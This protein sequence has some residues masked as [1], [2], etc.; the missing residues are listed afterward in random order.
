MTKPK[1]PVVTLPNCDADLGREEYVV[2]NF[3]TLCMEPAAEQNQML[4]TM[5]T[6]KSWSR[7]FWYVWL[8]IVIIFF[9]CAIGCALQSFRWYRRIKHRHERR[10]ARSA[11]TTRVYG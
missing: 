4:Y 2:N 1:N 8:M 7:D 3:G 9:F 10:V 6:V 5:P 11:G